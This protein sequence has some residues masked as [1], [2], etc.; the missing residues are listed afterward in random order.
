MIGDFI[1]LRADGSPVYNFCCAIDD[2]LMEITHVL[3]GEEHLPNTL[4]QL[5]IID[6][7]GFKRP[8]YGHLSLILGD[9][10]KKLSKRDGVASISD[11]QSQ[12]YLPE[13]LINYLALL[14]WS[15]PD[16][17]EI[18]SLPELAQAFSTDRLHPAAPH[19][20]SQKLRWVNHQQIQVYGSKKLYEACLPFL[21]KAN[22]MLP[23]SAQWHE[24]TLTMFQA[25]L[26]ILS[27][28]CPI[29]SRLCDHS[30]LLT[31]AAFD[32]LK[33][34]HTP[35]LLC[36]WL[37][38]LFSQLLPETITI[39]S[40]SGDY[41]KQCTLTNPSLPEAVDF[42]IDSLSKDQHLDKILPHT[43]YQLIDQLFQCGS[44]ELQTQLQSFLDNDVYQN[45]T[46]ILQD[47]YKVKG[48]ELFMPLRVA[49]L[50][51]NQ[52]LDLKLAC[53]LITLGS[54]IKRAVYAI[55]SVKA[56]T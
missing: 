20:D 23:Q 19:F 26:H 47:R 40:D 43:L 10:N 12:G 5:M 41:F 3:R 37:S 25:D 44:S 33:W 11:F 50:G 15:D 24:H 55:V 52:G 2:S 6:A 1:L 51:N 28:I 54:L 9:G 7:L 36:D 16:G 22:L 35:S 21:N 4:R 49:M 56:L 45:I 48:K 38:E 14:G 42:L 8:E 32:V 31:D 13:G 46:K 53:Q 17:R 18:L 29:F 39:P 34:K 27:D 30:A